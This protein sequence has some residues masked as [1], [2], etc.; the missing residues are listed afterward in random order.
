VE[1]ASY[2]TSTISG[3]TGTL[4]S[5]HAS[6]SKAVVENACLGLHT[7]NVLVGN[8]TFGEPCPGTNKTLTV[9]ATCKAT[10]SP[11]AICAQAPQGYSCTI[12]AHCSSGNCVDG[13]CCNT[14]CGGGSTIDAQV[15]SGVAAG[16]PGTPA[17]SVNGVCTATICRNVGTSTYVVAPG[18]TP[19]SP[20]F[21]P[22]QQGDV[23]IVQFYK[24][25]ATTTTVPSGWTFLSGSAATE[26]YWKRWNTGDGTTVSFNT[27]VSSDKTAFL[28]VFRDCGNPSATS[29]TGN[30][31]ATMSTPDATTTAAR[32]TVLRFYHSSDDNDQKNPT[33]PTGTTANVVFVSGSVALQDTTLAQDTSASLSERVNVAAGVSVGTATMNQTANANDSYTSHTVLMS[34]L[35]QAI[36]AAC[37]AG[38][39][40]TSGSCVNG[41]CS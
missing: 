19:V 29:F 39:D 25:S 34:T 11:Q 2:G 40:C 7:C 28:S 20:S 10:T 22:V 31:S 14:P 26:L 12:G 38:T 21:P 5:C 6:V 37:V 1:F 32:T 8:A 17:T 15:C 23:L 27:G 24:A 36:G 18:T 41:V 33:D 9:A 4:G 35:P 30:G 13:A 16:L 3:C